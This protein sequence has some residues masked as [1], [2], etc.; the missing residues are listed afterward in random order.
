MIG[1]S[2]TLIPTVA[3]RFR[4]VEEEETAQSLT[5]TPLVL[6]KGGRCSLRDR[7]G[8]SGI[9]VVTEL[10]RGFYRIR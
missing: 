3:C 4:S 10:S 7:E 6:G 1:V 5:P 2:D 8:K 9:V